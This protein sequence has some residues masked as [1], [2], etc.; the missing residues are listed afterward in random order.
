MQDDPLG[1]EAGGEREM[2]L[3]AGGH[4]APQPLLGE[5][6]QHGGAGEGLGGEHDV[7]VG[8][9]GVA[10]GVE[11]SAGAGA[12]VVLGDDV[13]GRAEL[14]RELDRVAAA[15]LEPAALVEAAAERECAWREPCRW[16]SR[17]GLSPETHAG[18]GRSAATPPRRTSTASHARPTRISATLSS[19]GA[20]RPA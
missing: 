17:A 14:A 16:P 15:H 7:E 1:R 10:A 4:V 6:A 20:V 5:Q 8:V 2:Q 11:E 9:A 13:G 12:Q 3:A 19:C 18:V